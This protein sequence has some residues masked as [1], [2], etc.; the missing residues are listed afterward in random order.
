MIH[1]RILNFKNFYFILIVEKYSVCCFVPSLV[2]ALDKFP[3]GER[4]F[5]P[6]GKNLLPCG[7]FN[8]I[9]A[10]QTKICYSP[11]AGTG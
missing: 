10:K 7:E 1:C 3:H 5:L 8:D 9:D 11:R 2:C 6:Y 4:F